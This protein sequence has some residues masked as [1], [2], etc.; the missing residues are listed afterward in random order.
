MCGTAKWL[1]CSETTGE[2]RSHCCFMSLK[3]K[4]ERICRATPGGLFFYRLARLVYDLIKFRT[5]RSLL[6]APPGHYSS[7]IPDRARIN[8]APWPTAPRSN[9]VLG[10]NINESEQLALLS[11]C[12]RYYMECPYTGKVDSSTPLSR[13]YPNNGCY[14]IGDA[15]TLYAFIRFF[16]PRRIIEIGSGFSSAVMLDTNQLFF[17]RAIQLTFVDPDPLRL[18]VCMYSD[19][20]THVQCIRNYVEESP[21]EPFTELEAHDILFIDSSHVVKHNSDLSYVF[22]YLIPRLAPG[23]IIHIHDIHWPFEYPRS[24]LLEGVAWN[25]SYFLKAFL[26]YNEAFKIIFFSS[27]LYQWHKAIIERAMPLYLQDPGS[28]L[29][30]Q[31]TKKPHHI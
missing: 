26:Q 28:S 5:F 23:V 18:Q 25:E 15:L 17:N 22:S 3:Y 7:P 27:F 1:W 8:H 13:Y 16:R 12:A 30:I 11:E 19:D 21:L 20:I 10:I 4:I 24:W 2:E 6:F 31:K 29:W 9:T 14:G